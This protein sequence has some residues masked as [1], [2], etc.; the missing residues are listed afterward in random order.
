MLTC[1]VRESFNES[2]WVV[3]C[4]SICYQL[5][6]EPFHPNVR[7]CSHTHCFW[8]ASE[9][10]ILRSMKKSKRQT[11]KNTGLVLVP[12]WGQQVIVWTVEVLPRGTWPL[13]W[14]LCYL[15]KVERL[16]AA[17]VLLRDAVETVIPK[18]AVLLRR[19]QSDAGVKELGEESFS[20]CH[21]R[22][23]WGGLKCLCSTDICH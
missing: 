20:S 11:F 6:G 23:G 8:L 18:P 22:R 15:H 9:T 3:H 2:R 14:N 17:A 10:W 7:V 5:E 4:V 1:L 16:R 19:T 13:W 21:H 12:S